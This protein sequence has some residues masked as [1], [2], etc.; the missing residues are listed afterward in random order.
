MM[1]VER[2][3]EH[4]RTI[5]AIAE[6][7]LPLLA[8]DSQPDPMALSRLRWELVRAMTAYQHFKHREIFDPAIKRGTGHLQHMAEVMKTD[9]VALG[10][11]FTRYVQHWSSVGT[12]DRWH[13]YRQ[14]ALAMSTRLRRHVEREGQAISAML[15]GARASGSPIWPDRTR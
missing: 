1:L 8:V 10:D 14:D 9:C 4:Q 13:E 7:A 11:E 5:A 6:R 3:V 2:L 15:R 12:A